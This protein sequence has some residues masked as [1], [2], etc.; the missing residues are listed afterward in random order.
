MNF[1]D[2]NTKECVA[3][4]FAGVCQDGA[5]YQ[6]IAKSAFNEGF[7]FISDEMKTISK[8]KMAHAAVLYKLMLDNITSTTENV[9]IEAGYPFEAHK[10]RTS[11]KDSSEIEE[12]Q[13]NNV[14]PHFAK[15]AQDEGFKEISK[16]FLLIA[17]VCKSNSKKLAHFAIKFE[18]KNLYSSS[19]NEKWICSN[20]GYSENSKKAWNNCPLC[21]YPKGYVSFNID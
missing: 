5:R 11:L 9:D 6:F 14:Y 17:S 3:R 16:L 7:S 8:N 20:C 10:L 4:A 13:A 1:N 18:S 21:S 12:Y 15:I 2:S 19:N